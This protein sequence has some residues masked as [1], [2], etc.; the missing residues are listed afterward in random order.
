M[1]VPA[2]L[3]LMSA[4][5]GARRTRSDHPNLPMTP[6]EIA[7]DAKRV[8]DAGATL[9]HLHVRDDSGGHSLDAERYRLAIEAVR[10]VVGER[11]VIQITTEAVGIYGPVAQMDV[12]RALRPEAVS[13]AIRELIPSDD[14]SE[15]EAGAAFFAWLREQRIAPHFILYSP[16]DVRRFNAYRAGGIIPQRSPFALFVLGRYVEPTEVRANDLLPFLAEHDMA[17]PWS[18]CAFGR[19][20]SAA[21]LIAAALG[22]HVRVGFENNLWR[23]DGTLADGNADLVDQVA[24]GARLMGRTPATIDQT[25]A[26]IAQTAA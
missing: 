14:P 6:D 9:L 12:V 23:A 26:L 2:P 16:E 21:A 4:P 17:N 11:M 20:E 8:A 22:G 7:A 25:R 18:V 1:S 13:L 24:S 5:N 3:V 15:I 10:A 19:V